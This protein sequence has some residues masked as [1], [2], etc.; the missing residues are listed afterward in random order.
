MNCPKCKKVSLCGCK[1]CVGRRKGTMPKERAF[2]FCG[3]GELQKCP[4]CR[5]VFHPD[6]LLD[7]DW[8]LMKNK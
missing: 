1:S 5:T 7:Y 3:N 2:D 4:Y 8:N 6:V